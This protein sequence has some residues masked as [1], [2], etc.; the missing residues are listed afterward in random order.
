MQDFTL[1]SQYLSKAFPSLKKKKKKPLSSLLQLI[2]FIH[3]LIIQ[4]KNA[5]CFLGEAVIEVQLVRKKSNLL[6]MKFH[7]KY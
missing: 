2:T 7:T 6:N 3:Y 1:F 4:Q 5:D